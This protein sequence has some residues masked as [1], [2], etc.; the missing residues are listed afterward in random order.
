[1]PRKSQEQPLTIGFFGLGQVPEGEIEATLDD[2]LAEV[3]NE[4]SFI[5]PVTKTHWTDTLDAIVAYAD[6]KEIPYQAVTD[7]ASSTARNLKKAIAGS[8]K[9]HKVARISQKIITALSSA[10]GDALLVVIWDDEDE[11]LEDICN[12]AVDKEIPVRDLTS[13]M[14]EVEF[15][16][17]GKDDADPAEDDEEK[18][19]K[20]K[21]EPKD[22]D[23][24]DEP[25]EDAAPDEDEDAGGIEIYTAEELEGADLDTLKAIAKDDDIEVPPRTRATTL[26][27]LILEF[28]EGLEKQKAKA[29]EVLKSVKIEAEVDYDRIAQ[30][31]AD[32]VREILYGDG[33][34]L[35]EALD[36]V[37]AEVVEK[38]DDLFKASLK[39][40]SDIVEGAASKA[41]TD[42]VIDVEEAEEVVSE[43]EPEDEPA[44]TT[45]RKRRI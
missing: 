25:A 12:R 15:E 13:S 43:N 1:M 5:L 11:E 26:R 41:T 21:A 23:E 6:A 36:A 17:D 9:S 42:D 38:V 16:D 24:D 45:R 8:T 4:V 22:K 37:V 44:P 35:N 18:P 34:P 30:S 31:V 20:T 10:T 39:R 40:I 14:E 29:D 2:Y 27:T 3:S 32:V 28:Q 33:S 7:E 19:A